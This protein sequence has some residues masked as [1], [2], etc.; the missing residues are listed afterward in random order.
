LPF[1]EVHETKLETL[2]GQFVTASEIGVVTPNRRDWVR[3]RR[4]EG[5]SARRASPQAPAVIFFASVPTFDELH[6]GQ[7]GLAA[8]SFDILLL[9][10]WRA[11]G[12]SSKLN[13]SVVKLR[14]A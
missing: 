3:R 13:T 2:P 14:R 10:D 9:D 4:L 8:S 11:D 12:V 5:L 6:A 1:C 7:M